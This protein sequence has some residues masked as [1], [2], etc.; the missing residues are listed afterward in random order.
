M[1]NI[2][3]SDGMNAVPTDG[4]IC[5][6]YEGVS[7]SMSPEAALR[8]AERLVLAAEEAMAARSRLNDN[9]EARG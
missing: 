3:S 2:H 8:T 5:L 6:M 4:R 1:V 7:V 9:R